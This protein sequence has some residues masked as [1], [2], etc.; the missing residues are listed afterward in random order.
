M[1]I[2][3][4]DSKSLS[5]NSSIWVILELPSVECL[6]GEWVTFSWFFLGEVILVCMNVT[7]LFIHFL[8]KHLF[9]FQFWV[10]MNYSVVNIHVH[11]H[12][13]NCF[14]FSGVDSN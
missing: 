10:F 8:L 13:D 7:L 12:V 3:I 5:D 6:L 4:V 11:N 1:L 14:C 9:C 2:L